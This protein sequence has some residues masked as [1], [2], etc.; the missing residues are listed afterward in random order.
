LIKC[1]SLDSVSIET[2]ELTD[3]YLRSVTAIFDKLRG[4]IVRW[5]EQLV[6]IAG[7]IERDEYYFGPRRI[8]GKRS[9]GASVKTIV[10]GIF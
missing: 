10:F 5:P 1:F 8:L 6:P 4:K 3:I 2:A 7:T 9:R